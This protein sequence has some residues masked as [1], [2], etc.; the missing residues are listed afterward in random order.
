MDST[1]VSQPITT[2]PEL[3]IVRGVRLVFVGTGQ[4]LGNSDVPGVG[5]NIH[6]TQR[7]SYYGL[8]DNLTS[9]PLISPLRTSLQQQT[10]TTTGLFRTASSNTVNYGTQKGWYID[11]PD[12]GERAVTHPVL[13]LGAL[14]FSS[15]IPNTDPCTPGGSSWLYFLD[16]ETGGFLSGS[17]VSW[18]AKSLG[19]QLA[20][21]GT[22]I[23]LPDGTVK[24]LTQGSGGGP[25]NVTPAPLPPNSGGIERVSWRELITE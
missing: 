17:T 3:G 16:Y 12:S 5:E 18:T 22:V 1:G 24:V 20:S 8:V 21:R 14:I 23:K 10:L 25:G 13:A 11:L 19:N 9:T 4:Y 6:A 2:T 7:Q 15:N